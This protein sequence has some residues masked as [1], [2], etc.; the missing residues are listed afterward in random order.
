MLSRRPAVPWLVFAE[1]CAFLTRCAKRKKKKKSAKQ[2]LPV[3]ESFFVFSKSSFFRLWTLKPRKVESGFVRVC[4]S[5]RFPLDACLSS[6]GSNYLRGPSVRRVQA[7]RERDRVICER[8]AHP[9][10][11]HVNPSRETSCCLFFFFFFAS[12]FQSGVE[13][14]IILPAHQTATR[15]EITLARS[16]KPPP[17]F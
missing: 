4:A 15:W 8:T 14:K 17:L 2:A 3:G 13:I 16:I 5:K 10:C 11:H 12:Q 6:T 1:R 9:V 7:G